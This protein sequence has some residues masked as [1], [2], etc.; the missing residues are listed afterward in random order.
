MRLKAYQDQLVRQNEVLSAQIIQA[1]KM[2]IA[3]L[4]ASQ[5]AH[6]LRNVLTAIVGNTELVLYKTSDWGV[7]PELQR[8]IQAAQHASRLVHQISDLGRRQS[9]DTPTCNPSV[10]I[11]ECLDLLQVLVPTG[12]AVD[13]V[14]PNSRDRAGVDKTALQQVVMNLI[15]NAVHAMDESGTL[16]LRV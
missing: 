16:A 5:A 7:H 10:V 6:D 12:I 8:V 4:L 3:G 13:W 2:E 11:D 9:N 1:Q 14:N 15:I